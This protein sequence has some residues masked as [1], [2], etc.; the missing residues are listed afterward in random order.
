VFSN[1]PE[2]HFW[3]ANK[4]GISFTHKHIL[5]PRQQL[6]PQKENFQLAGSV[7]QEYRYSRIQCKGSLSILPF[8]NPPP[9][10]RASPYS[11]RWF[12]YP[13]DPILEVHGEYAKRR[14][15]YYNKVFLDNHIKPQELSDFFTDEKMLKYGPRVARLLKH[16]LLLF[17]RDDDLTLQDFSSSLSKEEAEVVR[18]TK[19]MVIFFGANSLL[20]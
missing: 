4:V 9:M 6:L 16:L 10:S 7:Q 1:C 5:F 19:R 15:N 20:L 11:V 13:F 14:K 12:I 2:C 17:I 8:L 3:G 18:N